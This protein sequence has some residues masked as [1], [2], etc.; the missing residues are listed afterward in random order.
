MNI[1]R[2]LSGMPPVCIVRF[3]LLFKLKKMVSGL[4]ISILIKIDVSMF[5]TFRGLEI[6]FDR[7]VTTGVEYL[8]R[9]N[10]LDH[11]HLDGSYNRVCS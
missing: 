7:G 3:V 9:M 1:G 2:I 6:H 4:T 5:L 10:A 11:N 8:T